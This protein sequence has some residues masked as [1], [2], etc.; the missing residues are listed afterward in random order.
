MAVSSE[1]RLQRRPR[2]ARG[3]ATCSNPSAFSR[4]PRYRTIVLTFGRDIDLLLFVVCSC[5]RWCAARWD[6][7]ARFNA[8]TD[9]ESLS[10]ASRAAGTHSFWGDPGLPGLG[11]AGEHLDEPQEQ[12]TA[13]VELL[14]GPDASDAA[15]IEDC[16]AL[17]R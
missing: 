4:L 7:G 5:F 15:D 10:H 6:G 12:L 11:E 14:G 2:R 8:G 1:R 16:R 3:S 17:H 13:V 9:Q